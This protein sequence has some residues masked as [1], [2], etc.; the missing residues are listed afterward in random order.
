MSTITVSCT[1]AHYG[2]GPY[3]SFPKSQS[4]LCVKC[5]NE[6][7]ICAEVTTRKKE[8]KRIKSDTQ[9]WKE[10]NGVCYYFCVLINAGDYEKKTGT[11]MT[12]NDP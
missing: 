12:V 5:R 8:Q 6:A 7:N 3:S 11:F 9:A 4:A 1:Q 2:C 10:K